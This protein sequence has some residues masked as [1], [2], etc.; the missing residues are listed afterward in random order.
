MDR[1]T[2]ATLCVIG[3]WKDYK[4]YFLWRIWNL[5]KLLTAKIH[6]K[7]NFEYKK[8]LYS[9][10][11]RVRIYLCTYLQFANTQNQ[12]RFQYVRFYIIQPERIRTVRRVMQMNCFRKR[13]KIETPSGD[14]FFLTCFPF[15]RISSFQWNDFK[16]ERMKLFALSLSDRWMGNT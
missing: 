4:L 14:F 3:A 6:L 10:N 8:V 15:Y 1:T 12:Y 16:N 7:F 9:S 2:L 5:C 13:T 11:I